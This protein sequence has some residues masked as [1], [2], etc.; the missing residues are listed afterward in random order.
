[1]GK[2]FII[3]KLEIFNCH[4]RLTEVNAFRCGS[5]KDRKPIRRLVAVTDGSQSK[6]T[7]GPISGWRQ[8]S[9]VVSVA[10]MYL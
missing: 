2:A 5:F 4:V 10:D 1:M 7:D 3:Y 6:P 8:R 9:G